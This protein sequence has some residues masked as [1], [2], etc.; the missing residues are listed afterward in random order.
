MPCTTRV[1]STR[2]AQSDDQ[3][4]TFNDT[5][6]LRVSST[7]TIDELSSLHDELIVAEPQRDV[8]I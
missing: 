2:G 6:A 7:N 1:R 3:S 8:A 4:L 5:L